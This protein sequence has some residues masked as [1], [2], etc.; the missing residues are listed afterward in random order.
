MQDLINKN[1]DYILSQENEDYF[2]EVICGT[3]AIYTICFKLD[4][5]EKSRFL[6]EGESYLDQ[7]AW[8]VRDWP[9]EYLKRRV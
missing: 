4:E 5:D 3:V 1:W 2:L 9:E 8:R 6:A 7:L